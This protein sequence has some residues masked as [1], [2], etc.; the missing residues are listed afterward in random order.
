MEGGKAEAASREQKRSGLTPQKGKWHKSQS[1]GLEENVAFPEKG[2]RQSVWGCGLLATIAP[3]ELYS[4]T[5]SRHTF[6]L[7]AAW[8][9]GVGNVGAGGLAEDGE[10]TLTR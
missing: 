1:S 4:F 10:R 3:T 9:F 5:K 8:K 7:I 2:K 6:L